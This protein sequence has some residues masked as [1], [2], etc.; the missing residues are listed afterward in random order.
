LDAARARGQR[1]GRPPAV[2][3]ARIRQARVLLTKPEESVSS[4][5]RLLGISRSMLYTHV[6]ELKAGGRPALI[7]AVH[8]E[9]IA[10]YDAAQASDQHQSARLL[11]DG[12]V[13]VRPTR[14][15]PV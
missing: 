9:A 3:P 14:R 10:A 13:R 5:A 1:L 7:E 15:Q 6:P 12:P 8:T 11:G 4:I 2:T